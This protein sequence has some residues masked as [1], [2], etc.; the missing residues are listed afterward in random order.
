[1]DIT[2]TGARSFYVEDPDG[3]PVEFITMAPSRP[4]Q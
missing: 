2:G 3:T 4:A 1:V